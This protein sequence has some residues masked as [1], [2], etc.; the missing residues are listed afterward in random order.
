MIN[1]YFYKYIFDLAEPLKR[2]QVLPVVLDHILRTS[3]FQDRFPGSRKRLVR[4]TWGHK[5]GCE[6]ATEGM[7]V[8][9]ED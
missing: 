3:D 7:E 2:S 4:P 5:Q 1:P 9:S 6:V 8:V